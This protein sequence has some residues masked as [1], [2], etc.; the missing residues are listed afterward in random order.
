VAA[1]PEDAGRR[2]VARNR[3]ATH[4]YFID[5]R[6][7]AGMMLQGTEVKSL[8]EGKA[9]ISE[10]YAAEQAGDLYLV[11]ATIP[12]YHGGN[13]FNHEPRRP[14]KLLL[15]KRELA[16]LAGA[17][18][19]QG[20]TL[21]PLSLYFNPRGLAKIEIGLGRGK[22]IYDKRASIKERDWQRDKQ[23]LLRDKG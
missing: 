2:I 16:K 9:N 4:D 22:K 10:A 23:R 20:Q 14:R 15:Q 19:K 12:E 7:E 13:R 21:V 17:V 11:N 8:R 18:R 5:E 3:R 1:K 6:F